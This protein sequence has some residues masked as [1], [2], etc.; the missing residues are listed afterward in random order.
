MADDLLKYR[1]AFASI[2]GMG[3]ELARQILD[4]VPSERDF[5]EMKRA[6]LAQLLPVKSRLLGD[7]YRRQLLDSTDKELEFL[8][9]NSIGVTYFTDSDFPRRLAA[10]P[11]GPVLIYYKGDPGCFNA[12]KMISIVGTRHATPYGTHF[13][14]SLVRDI[15]GCIADAVIVSGLA[16]GIDIA[17]HRAALSHRVPTMAVLAHGLNTIY[18]SQHRNDALNILENGGMIITDYTSQAAMSRGNFLARNRIIAGLS[19]CTIVVESAEKGGAIVTAGI[20]QSYNRDVFAIPGKV[21]DI[22]SAGCN[23]LIRNN[24]AT[25]ITSCD[26]LMKAMRWEMIGDETT[27][28]QRSIFPELT[29]EEQPVVDYLRANSDVH[30][31]T[32]AAS[33]KIPVAELMGLLVELEFKGIVIAS[34]GN[35]YSSAMLQ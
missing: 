22:Y 2:R 3:C 6:D 32:L 28:R 9:K 34:P 7:D 4:L 1:I 20:A 27:P 35:R 8:N 12:D 15:S 13:C 14:D 17:A 29:A 11:D 18:P 5:F 21:T 16:Y 19:D 10:T 24:T 26:D 31:N 33:L 30:I 23:S 25:L